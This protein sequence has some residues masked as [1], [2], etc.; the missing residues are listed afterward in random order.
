MKNRRDFLKGTSVLGGLS[1][2]AGCCDTDMALANNE[3]ESAK[4]FKENLLDCLG[5]P[6]PETAD[7]K[8]KV[9]KS[10]TK[11]GYRLE[12][13]DYEVEEGDRVKAIMLIPDGVSVSNPAPAVAVWHQHNGQ[14]NLGKSEPAGLAG[15]PQHHTGVALA[16]LGYV[17][18]CPDALCF[19]SRQDPKKKLKGGKYERFEF[20]E[21]VIDGKCL[22]WKNI[23][24]MKRAVDYMASRP[25]VDADRMGCY[26]HSM[27]STHTWLIAPWEERLNVMVGNCCLPNYAA[28]E[29]TQ[30]LHCYSNFIPGLNQYGDLEDI[31]SLIAPRRVHVNLG[32]VDIG[33]PIPEAKASIVKIASV[34][35]AAGAQEKFTHFIEKGADHVLTDKMWGLA[36]EA[37]AEL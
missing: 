12:H 14:Y 36:K 13:L 7:L 11:V 31:V 15:D 35:K 29:R 21:Y 28:I 5:G 4:G 32:E 22:A 20:L 8:A 19:E 26:G 9:S 24:D 17:V 37:F 6:W 34:Y 10:E 27:G 2:V 18:L 3:T 1:L 30:L 33:T 16:K 23:L 25:E